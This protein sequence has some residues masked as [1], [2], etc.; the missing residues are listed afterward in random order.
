MVPPGAGY[1]GYGG[2]ATVD[3]DAETRSGA[4]ASLAVKFGV[5]AYA[6]GAAANVVVFNDFWREIQR[7]AD[8]SDPTATPQLEAAGGG[9]GLLANLASLVTIVAGVLVLVWFHRAATNAG[10]LGLPQ[11]RSPGWAVAGFIIPIVNFWFPYQSACDFFPPGSPDRKIVG[12]W[13]AAWLGAQFATIVALFA[14]FSSVGAGLVVV[15]F[16]ALLYL[17]AAQQLI[18]MAER[19]REVHSDL[20]TIRTGG[21]PPPVQ[22]GWGAA[23]PMPPS[24]PPSAPPSVPP[25]PPSPPEDP[26]DP[27]APR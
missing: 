26:P 17:T 27:W 4:S 20:Y 3:L 14:A 1:G 25:A 2:G 10:L 24:V 6:V 23:P 18:L 11:R 12:R 15:A 16:Q 5:V 9:L 22:P 8:S 19:A 13:W 21:A 7:I